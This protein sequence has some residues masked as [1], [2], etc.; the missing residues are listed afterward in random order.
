M[1]G[2]MT[3]G[4]GE[5]RIRSRQ[6]FRSSSFCTSVGTITGIQFIGAAVFFN[7]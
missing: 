3:L 1:E 7:K 6:V 2:E 5:K 4:V